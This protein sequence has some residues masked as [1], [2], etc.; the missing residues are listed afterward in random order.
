MTDPTLWTLMQRVETL[1]YRAE[2]LEAAAAGLTPPWRDLALDIAAR[3]RQLAEHTYLAALGGR[4]E[5]AA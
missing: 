1:R 4:W 5:R 2:C 3:L